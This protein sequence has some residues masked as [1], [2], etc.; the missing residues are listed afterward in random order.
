MMYVKELESGQL[1]DL[2]YLIFWK[3]FPEEDTTWEPA[4]TI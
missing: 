1:L 4:L 2:Y 3:G